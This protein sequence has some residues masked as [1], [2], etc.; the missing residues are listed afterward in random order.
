MPK[1]QNP[2][3]KYILP[4]ISTLFI[5]FFCFFP[6]QVS[7]VPSIIKLFVNY[8]TEFSDKYYFPSLRNNLSSIWELSRLEYR[9]EEIESSSNIEPNKK[10]EQINTIIQKAKDI[11]GNEEINSEILHKLPEY[12]KE[13][14]KASVISKYTG[15]F[16]LVN[17][18]WLIAILGLTFTIGPLIYA[19][20]GSIVSKIYGT[21]IYPI[22]NYI[23]ENE[24]Y[25]YLGYV[26]SLLLV[27]DGMRVKKGWGLYISLTGA[28]FLTGLFVYT[29]ELMKEGVEE[30]PWTFFWTITPILYFSLSINMNSILL[31]FVT[32]IYC[33]IFL[34]FYKQCFG[35]GYILKYEFIFESKVNIIG[36]NSLVLMTFYIMLRTL[37]LF[38]NIL[39]L[40]KSPIQI[41]GATTYFISLLIFVFKSYK[42]HEEILSYPKRQIIFICSVVYSLFLGYAINLPSLSNTAY[43]FTALFILGKIIELVQRIKDSF[44][45]LVFTVSLCLWIFSFYLHK[46]PEMIVSIFIGS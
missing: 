24:L 27:C 16:S 2:N 4:I 6:N 11:L 45:I 7:K 28:I 35:L 13:L 23:Y 9:L 1:E 40:Y 5:L 29:L 22:V 33:Y 10:E 15:I 37:H 43:I 34:G 38:R 46:H 18:I 42:Y 8:D 36:L 41:L 19:S 20:L 31:S 32:T 39:D 12:L 30:K 25:I 21:Y 44:V 26:I 14:N 3:Q 17:L